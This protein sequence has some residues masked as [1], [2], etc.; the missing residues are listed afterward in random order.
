MGW[1]DGYSLRTRCGLNWSVICA[2]TQRDRH[3][4]GIGNQWQSRRISER[5]LAIYFSHAFAS[6]ECSVIIGVVASICGR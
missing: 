5:D 6:P 1:P 3:A 2:R 4:R